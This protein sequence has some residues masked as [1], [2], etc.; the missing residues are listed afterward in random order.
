MA[1]A[2]RHDRPDVVLLDIELP[3]LKAVETARTIHAE[4]GG[5]TAVIVLASPHADTG[6][7]ERVCAALRAGARG[8]LFKDAEPEELLR[9]V[10]TVAAGDAMLA[11]R[12]TRW[13]LPRFAASGLR[14]PEPTLGKLTRRERDV[15]LEVA[16]GRSNLEIGA[17]LG[18]TEFTVKSYLY[19]LMQKLQLN[20]RAR[21]VVAAYETGLV[22]PGLHTERE[23]VVAG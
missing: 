21:L 13:L 1:A 20:S 23:R 8:C 14:D 4:S 11:P 12:V 16:E 5:R 22:T 10:R 6:L 9:A 3:G 19:H 17:Q 15:L 7:E 18:L 2:V